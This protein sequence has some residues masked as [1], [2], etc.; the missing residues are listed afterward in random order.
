MTVSWLSFIKN[1]W[2]RGKIIVISSMN[3]SVILQFRN[4]D[5][6]ESIYFSY[7]SPTEVCVQYSV[8]QYM[9]LN[10]VAKLIS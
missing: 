4:A 8:N 6:K 10:T 9:V 3:G 7:A 2:M 5:D 1:L